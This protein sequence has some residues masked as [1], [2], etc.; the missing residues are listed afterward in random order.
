MK[1]ILILLLSVFAANSAEGDL[2]FRLDGSTPG[3]RGVLE[4]H[5]AGSGLSSYLRVRWSAGPLSFV[6]MADKAR[7]EE[8]GDILAGGARWRSGAGPEIS[9]GWLKAHLGSGLV[10]S[11]PQ[12]FSDPS[13]LSLYKPPNFRQRTEPATSAGA[14]RE[15]PLIGAAARLSA[16]GMEITVLGAW[17]PVDSISGGRHRTPSEIAG[18]GAYDEKLGAL[19]VSGG[20]WGFTAAAASSSD[21][22]RGEWVR[23]GLD[24][25]AGFE[26]FTAAGELAAGVDSAAASLAGWA[27]LQQETSVFKHMLTAVRNPESFPRTRSSAPISR[28]CDLGINYGLRWRFLPRAVLRAGAG[29]YFTEEEDLLITAAEGEYR[30]PW[31]MSLSAG[32]RSRNEVDES[33]WR[34]WLLSSWKPH[35]FFSTG[36]RLQLSGWSLG[37]SS[38]T[39]TGIEVKFRY[40]PREWLS[41]DLGSAFS[42]TDGWNSR[43]Y[44]SGGYF[45]GKFS[46]ATL[47]GNMTFLY[48]VLSIEAS[49][50]LFFRAGAE[51][52]TKRGAESLG[53]GWEETQ[54]DS[55]TR[56]GLQ[57]DYSFE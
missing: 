21:P 4:K 48:T 27:C 28:T 26:N 7:G 13:P 10:F 51:H 45:P 33:S 1:L 31:S 20:P 8:W 37:D 34:S 19:R 3:C 22:D 11:H 39:G 38:E 15:D 53:S 47:Y 30:F 18:R 52:L 40:R 35:D 9:A 5:Y 50:G 14:C 36:L 55:R 12:G 16:G 29:G 43:V 41:L 49:P 2:R 17:S 6:T 42:S 44:S 23:A 25:S 32:I 24:I 54:G 56:L 57:L 46:S